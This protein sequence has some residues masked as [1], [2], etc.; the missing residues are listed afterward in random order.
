[1]GWA[2]LGSHRHTH[3]QFYN[4]LMKSTTLFL[5][6]GL[7]LACCCSD[8]AGLV[9]AQTAPSAPVAD[10][11][12]VAPLSGAST[13]TAV[14]KRFEHIQIEDSGARIDERRLGGD[15]Q[16]ITVHPK[17]NMPAYQVAPVTGDRTW[18]VLG[19]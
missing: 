5:R 3:G 8:G 13:A 12:P 17:G 2:V 16:S 14:N 19:F 10:A 15:T 1:M 18:K 4:G 7:L 6:Y 9:Q 11:T